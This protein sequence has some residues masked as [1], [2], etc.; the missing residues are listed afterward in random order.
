[1][2]EEGNEAGRRF[3]LWVW[4][5]LLALPLLYVLSSGPVALIMHRAGVGE[6]V[7]PVVYAP[8]WWLHKNT[9]LR[10]PLEAYDKLWVD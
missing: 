1:M 6:R 7:L 10:K 3:G 4:L 9:T 5:A 2:A 8:L